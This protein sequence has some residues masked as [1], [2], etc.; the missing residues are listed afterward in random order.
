MGIIERTMRARQGLI[1]R[2]L[3]RILMRGPYFFSVRD[4]IVSVLSQGLIR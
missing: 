4:F 1:N 2:R 3:E